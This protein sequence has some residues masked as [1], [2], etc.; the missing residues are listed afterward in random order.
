MEDD[1]REKEMQETTS[2]ELQNAP[3]SFLD[4]SDFF[5]TLTVGRYGQEKSS[6]SVPRIIE[7]EIMDEDQVE[8]SAMEETDKEDKILEDTMLKRVGVLQQQMAHHFDLNRNFLHYDLSDVPEVTEASNLQAALSVHSYIRDNTEDDLPALEDDNDLDDDEIHFQDQ[9]RDRHRDQDR[10]RDREEDIRYAPRHVLVVNQSG[11]RPASDVSLSL[12]SFEQTQDNETNETSLQQS[13]LHP[14]SNSS[15]SFSS[16][17]AFRSRN[18]KPRPLRS[19][20]C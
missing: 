15:S 11:R 3:Q 13:P 14:P 8:S 4:K 19:D 6:L 9:H 7:D 2:M 10:D 18:S 5:K 17:S 20:F 16:S 1:D 12:P